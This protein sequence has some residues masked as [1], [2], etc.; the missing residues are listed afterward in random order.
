MKTIIL[1]TAVFFVSFLSSVEAQSN[2]GGPAYSPEFA[3]DFKQE[4]KDPNFIKKYVANCMQLV[5]SAIP[6]ACRRS[7]PILD[8]SH[9]KDLLGKQKEA[10]AM[11]DPRNYG[12][13]WSYGPRKDGSLGPRPN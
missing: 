13:E 12:R 8:T 3:R 1:L 5:R 10:Q 6:E 7:T 2:R 11:C 4:M 9:C